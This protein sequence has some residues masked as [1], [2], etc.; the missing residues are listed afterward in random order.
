MFYLIDLKTLAYHL[1]MIDILQIIEG[2]FTKIVRPFHWKH[3]LVQKIITIVLY[4]Y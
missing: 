3:L 2:N 4:F 1:L